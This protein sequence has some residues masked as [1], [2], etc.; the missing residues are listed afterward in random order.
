MTFLE[1]ALLILREERRPLT[2]REVFDLAMAKGLLTTAGRTPER[3]LTSALYQAY[4]KRTPRMLQKLETRGEPR[5]ARG[6]VRWQ[7]HE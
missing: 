7:W 2:S 3:T 4:A 5:A 1:A 6:T